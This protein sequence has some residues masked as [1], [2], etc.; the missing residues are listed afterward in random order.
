MLGVAL[1]LSVI[2]VVVL[3]AMYCS[4]NFRSCAE[5]GSFL[6]FRRR[7]NTPDMSRGFERMHRLVFNQCLLCGHD[8]SVSH[9]TYDSPAHQPFGSWR[10]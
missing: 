10:H 4:G 2:S 8:E 6:T 7:Q 3:T 9:S 1:A 5:C